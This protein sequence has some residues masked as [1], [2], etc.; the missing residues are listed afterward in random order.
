MQI[1][2]PASRRTVRSFTVVL[3]P[4][5]FFDVRLPIAPS[6]ANRSAVKASERP[7][8]EDTDPEE[9]KKSQTGVRVRLIRNVTY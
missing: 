4:T 1:S 8:Q 9:E 5:G 3:S 7:S 6:Q 2:Q